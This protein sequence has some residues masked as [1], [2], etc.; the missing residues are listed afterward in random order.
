MCSVTKATSSQ[1]TSGQQ[2]KM[3]LSAAMVAVSIVSSSL[4]AR[5][6]PLSHLSMPYLNRACA[7]VL[8][9]LASLAWFVTYYSGQKLRKCSPTTKHL[10]AM[11]KKSALPQCIVDLDKITNPEGLS[12]MWKDQVLNKG[13]S[14]NILLT[15]VTGYVGRAFLFQLLREIDNAEPKGNEKIA[16]KVYVMARAKERKNQTAA[17]R[18]EMIRDEPMFEPYKKLW[19]EVV[20][21]APS[22]DLQDVNCGMKE[23]V[24]GMLAEAKITHVVH[25]AADVNF[26]RPLADSAGINISPALQLISLA[27][28]WS[29]CKRFVHCSTAFVNPGTGSH[30]D[31]MP[32]KLFPLGKYDPQDLY[33]SMRGDQKLALAVKEELAFPN[34]YV[35]TKCVA[36]HLVVRSIKHMELKIVRPAIVGPAW[37]LPE[38]GWNG[39]KPSTIT[40]LFLLWGTRVIRCAALSTKGM[41]MIPVDVVANGIIHAMISP[42]ALPLKQNKTSYPNKLP[43]TIRNLIWS[44]KSPKQCI[45]GLEMAYECIPGAVMKQHFSA[46]ETAISFALIDIVYKIPQVFPILH[47]IFNLGPLYLLQFICWSVKACGISSVLEQVPVVKLL[48][49]SDMIT[50]Y[51]PYMGRDYYFESSMDVPESMDMHQYNACL[52]KATHSFWTTLFPG[53]IEDL[54]EMELL[55]K[56]RLDLWWALT[57]PSRTFGNRIIAYL[58][59]KILRETHGSATVDVDSLE[60]VAGAM[61]DLEVDMKEKKQCV[62]LAS[63][64][65]SPMD[66]VLAKFVHFSMAGLGTDVP[67]TIADAD[68][69][70]SKLGARLGSIK[71][72]YD[73]HAT[74]SANLQDSEASEAFLRTLA[75]SPGEHDY[76]VVP[77]CM[78]YAQENTEHLKQASASELGLVDMLKLY[79]QVCIQGKHQGA[80]GEAR[81]SYG[82]PSKM[83][84]TADIKPVVTHVQRE[85]CRLRSISN[86]HLKA[87]EVDLKIPT[88]TLKGAVETLGVPVSDNDKIDESTENKPQQAPSP[89]TSVDNW[90]LHKQW[91]PNFAPYLSESHPAWA[92][93]I[94]GGKVEAQVATAPRNREIEAVLKAISSVFDAADYLA[95]RA[96]VSL[97]QKNVENPNVPDLVKEMEALDGELK[98]AASSFI[99]EAAASIAVNNR[100]S[101]AGPSGSEDEKKD[102]L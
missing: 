21:A 43:V 22:G 9:F 51:K 98:E 78:E 45:S 5:G 63:T 10:A 12:Q 65:Q 57:F 89:N 61:M 29:T 83:D 53:T 59:C 72:Q 91:V 44:H 36:E 84:S 79:W 14:F 47:L 81:I 66:D 60:Q 4:W 27:Q 73:R 75:N 7:V 2:G 46:T 99:F 26:N 96:K 69:Q 93:Y 37:V 97:H 15:G 17:Q 80:F 18:L 49:F 48:R 94:A 19:D 42:S 3:L 62:L 20:V 28:Q 88:A 41:P 6:L 56:G 71:A 85:H 55:P 32:E 101:V 30:G 76:T 34:N 35:F 82:K 33:D 16:H 1:R 74:I 39:E 8:G 25:C 38:P 67:T 70:N 24:I 31:P 58:G 54:S 92:T 64:Y 68:L 11:S 86:T 100:F 52:F 102:F 77:I 23:E 95:I 87:A 13:E 90:N 50:L 40:A